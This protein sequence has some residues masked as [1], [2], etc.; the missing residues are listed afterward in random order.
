[1]TTTSTADPRV[2]GRSDLIDALPWARLG[3][4]RGA[5][6]WPAEALV[7]YA[8]GHGRGHLTRALNVARL[9]GPATVLHTADGPLPV[10]P[11]GVQMQRVRLDDDALDRALGQARMLI[12]D[13]FPAGLRGEVRPTHLARVAVSVLIQRHVKTEAYP[14]Y[15]A[16]ARR[17]GCV[18]RPYPPAG[19]EWDDEASDADAHLG[20]CVGYLVR[21]LRRGAAGAGWSVMGRFDGLAAPIADALRAGERVEGIVDTL[22]DQPI[23]AVGAGYNTTYELLTLGLPFALVP[24]TKRFDDPWRRAERLGRA[25]H[26]RAALQAFIGRGP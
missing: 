24:V 23:V 8:V 25:I 19:C 7:I 9:L 20:P 6:D 2:C 15:H 18:I 21:P 22:P 1:M 3:W 14:E 5:P 13:T 12:V 11:P 10:A 4:S 26:S 16:W 17:Y